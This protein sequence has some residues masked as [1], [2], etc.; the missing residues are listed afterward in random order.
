M[1]ICAYT[2]WVTQI[3]GCYNEGPTVLAQKAPHRTTR[4]VFFP[5]VTYHLMPNTKTT[6]VQRSPGNQCDPRSR[7]TGIRNIFK[8]ELWIG[9]KAKEISEKAAK[10][11]D[12]PGYQSWR[13]EVAKKG[14]AGSGQKSEG[15]ASPGH[16]STNK[17]CWQHIWHCWSVEPR[18]DGDQKIPGGWEVIFRY[19]SVSCVTGWT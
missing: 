6:E 4:T 8:V 1:N 7:T 3:T 16:S 10:H 11:K 19:K 9:W 12:I 5:F 2:F 14:V 13:L 15:K 18:R 17:P